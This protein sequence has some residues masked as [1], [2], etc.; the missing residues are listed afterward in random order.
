M[1]HLSITKK[2]ADGFSSAQGVLG[3]DGC[4][5]LF[6]R[7]RKILPFILPRTAERVLDCLLTG[8]R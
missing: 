3:R 2:N 1:N 6:M 4:V 7:W 8:K 5:F